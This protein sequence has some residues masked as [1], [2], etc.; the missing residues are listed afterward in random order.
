MLVHQ[1]CICLLLHEDLVLRL[2]QRVLRMQRVDHL[3]VD[4]FEE[5]LRLP[6]LLGLSGSLLVIVLRDDQHVLIALH[7]RR[8]VLS[9]DG[10]YKEVVL[11]LLSIWLCVTI[12]PGSLLVR[13]LDFARVRL[14]NAHVH[15]PA[16]PLGLVLGQVLLLDVG[17]RLHEQVRG[18][19]LVGDP[20]QGS[21][22]T[23]DL[24]VSL[25]VRHLVEVVDGDHLKHLDVCIILLSSVMRTISVN[26]LRVF[27]LV[28]L[29]L[30]PQRKLVIL[31]HMELISIFNWHVSVK[32]VLRVQVTETVIVFLLL[33]G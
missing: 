8:D 13:L 24:Q 20:F 19:P 2:I 4:F 7:E 27:L 29:E 15:L 1:Q 14:I 6:A 16:E 30:P 9:S 26:K 3:L 21:V 18:G 33:L 32:I 23:V 22:L 28:P 17:S 25:L 11:V 12:V 5:L 31:L 10:R